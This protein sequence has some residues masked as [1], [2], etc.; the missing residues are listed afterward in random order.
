MPGIFGFHSKKESAQAE[1]ILTALAD[2]AGLDPACRVDRFL[3]SDKCVGLGRASLG[4]LNA[5]RQPVLQHAGSF[6]LI[7][8][9]GELYNNPGKQSDP[10]FV[11]NLYEK[12]GDSC[13]ARLNGLFHF[14]LY[15]MRTSQIKL[16]SD[17]FG[18]QPLYFAVQKTG[19]WFAGGMKMLLSV[20]EIAKNLDQQ[21]V[22]DFMHYG[23]VLGDKTLFREIKLLEPGSLLTYTLAS[24]N[25]SVDEYWALESLFGAPDNHVSLEDVT[26]ELIAAV[27]RRSGAR[28]KLGLSLSGGLDSRGI[29]AGLGPDA[30]GIST[31]TLGL[32]GCADQR[33]AAAMSKV[34]GTKHEFIE[35]DQHYLKDYEN[36]AQQMVWLSDGLYHPHESTEMLALAYFKRAEFDVLLRGHGGE[37]AKAALA[38]PVMVRPEVESFSKG[39]GILD[40]IFNSTNLVGRDIA[41]EKLF[42]RDFYARTKEGARHSLQASCGHLVNDLSPPDVCLFYYIREHVRRQA[43]ASLEIFRSQIEVRMPYVDE[44]FLGLLLKLPLDQRRRGEVHYQL[45]RKCMPAL[46]K[47]PDANT[48]APLDAGVLRLFLTDKVNAVM[49]RLSF[50]GFRHYTEFQSWYRGAFRDNLERILFSGELQSREIFNM[51]E[52]RHIADLHMAGKGDFAHFLGT[53]VGLELSLRCFSDGAGEGEK[54]SEPS[55]R[56]AA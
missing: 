6:L 19:L 53:A 9:H 49:K 29:L 21:S 39:N 41:A 43:V 44:D 36:L 17:K 42:T 48:G 50:A 27:K 32:P 7:I 31:Y 54:G 28:A 4:I 34:A 37:M 35:L 55:K 11:L 45:I 22:A 33:L 47:I 14:A 51:S 3:D 38:Y 18:L 52:L 5:V 12:Y 56:D 40:F 26:D 24:G 16:F 46:V 13:A 10:E 23:H 8:F 1:R 20:P 15:D 30:A 2:A 25:Y